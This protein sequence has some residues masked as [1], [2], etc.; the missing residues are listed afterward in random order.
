MSESEI[1]INIKDSLQ[2]KPGSSHILRNRESSQIEFK[3]T[4]NFGS[5]SKYARTMAAYANTRGGYIIF[6]VKPSPHELAG[7]NINKFE[8]T[9]SSKLTEYLNTC[10]SPELQWQIGLIEIYGFQ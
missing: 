1:E 9:D 5:R 2:L 10:L 8:Q 3:E 7:V 4:F 6:G